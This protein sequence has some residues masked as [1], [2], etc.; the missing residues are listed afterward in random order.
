MG[1]TVQITCRNTSLLR[2]ALSSC[3][4][5]DCSKNAADGYLAGSSSCL[6]VVIFAFSLPC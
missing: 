1:T 4:M 6:R 2:A 3:I 5:F